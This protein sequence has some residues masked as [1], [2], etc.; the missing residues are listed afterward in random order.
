MQN[1]VKYTAILF[2]LLALLGIPATAS[3]GIE[4]VQGKLW[5]EEAKIYDKPNGKV[6]YTATD[7]DDMHRIVS[8][9]D[10]A[11]KGWFSV[12][13]NNVPVSEMVYGYV[14][15]KTIVAYTKDDAVLY[16]NPNMQKKVATY[17]KNYMAYFLDYDGLNMIQCFISD[18]TNEHT[19]WFPDYSLTLDVE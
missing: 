11:E 14:P 12:S 19:G 9:G 2:L 5:Q 10:K 13:T 8:I 4:F 15:E 16:N 6:I 1:S 17:G 3:A 18:G 7:P